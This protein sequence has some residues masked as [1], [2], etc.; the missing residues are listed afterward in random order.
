MAKRAHWALFF[1]VTAC[2]SEG[3]GGSDGNDSR[4]SETGSEGPSTSEG[5]TTG[6][7]SGATMASASM[8][9]T[10]ATTAD[11]TSDDPTDSGEDPSG[12]PPCGALGEPCC[13]DG[14]CDEGACLDDTCVAFAGAFIDGELCPD[15]PHILAASQCGCPEGFAA[16]E[17]MSVLSSGCIK[18][19]PKS[20]L[21]WVD[22]SLYFCEAPNYIAGRSD[23][24]GAYLVA[25]RPGSGCGGQP[26]CLV[27]NAYAGDE[28]QCPDQSSAIEMLIFAHCDGEI[29]DP[30]PAYRLGVCLGDGPAVTIA[31]VV[32]R[33]GDECIETFPEANCAC[34]AG[35]SETSL[36]LIS[37]A[38]PNIAGDFGLCVRQ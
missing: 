16:S 32:F 29:P 31:G 4:A 7:P 11:A 37:E 36:R 30:P 34:P 33:Q 8:S 35:F 1:F 20:E 3:L 21:P 5:V 24:G 10:T 28:C 18:E 9:S 25:N 15:C 23:W 38:V 12:P 2:F 6:D 26:D 27:G 14:A 22:E 13:D 19:G 17:A